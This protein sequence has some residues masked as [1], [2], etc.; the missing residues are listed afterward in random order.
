HCGWNS[1]LESVCTEQNLNCAFLVEK[2]LALSLRRRQDGVIDKAVIEE[3]VRVLMNGEE[4]K[5]IRRNV[6]ELGRDAK[7]AVVQGSS[8]SANLEL[9]VEGLRA[10]KQ[11]AVKRV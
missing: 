2:K 11:E 9:F 1:T 3:A 8:S 6:G 7:R 10:T 5:E 4:G